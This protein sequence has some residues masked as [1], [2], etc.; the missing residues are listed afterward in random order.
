MPRFYNYIHNSNTPSRTEWYSGVVF[1]LTSLLRFNMKV[2]IFPF[3]WPASRVMVEW[4]VKEDG[5]SL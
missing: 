2:V 1:F 5:G 4:T 3:S